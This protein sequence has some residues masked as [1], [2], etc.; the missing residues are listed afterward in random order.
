[1]SNI[2]QEII[3]SYIAK[4]DELF[5]INKFNLTLGIHAIIIFYIKSIEQC[6]NTKLEK[7]RLLETG[8]TLLNGAILRLE[9]S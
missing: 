5:E 9:K 8:L 1:M 7:K 3:K 2:E 4:I 6:D